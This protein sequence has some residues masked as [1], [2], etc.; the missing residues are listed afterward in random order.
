MSLSQIHNAGANLYNLHFCS[1]IWLPIKL[2]QSVFLRGKVGGQSR[3][4]FLPTACSSW[5]DH[6]S[7]AF[8]LQQSHSF[9]WQQLH[10]AAVFLSFKNQLCHVFLP[11]RPWD[12]LARMP[13]SEV[14]VPFPESPSFQYRD[15]SKVEQWLFIRGLFQLHGGPSSKFRSFNNSQFLHSF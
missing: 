2:F 3:D 10:A 8:S 11:Q 6:L 13:F 14:W 1:S 4:V 12:Q 15:T 9:L 5:V 7:K